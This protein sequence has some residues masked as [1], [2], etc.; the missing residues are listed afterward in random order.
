MCVACGV[1]CVVD[2]LCDI[3]SGQSGSGQS[4]DG[5]VE[6][7]SAVSSSAVSS[8]ASSSAVSSAVL[9]HLPRI[10]KLQVSTQFGDG[11]VE[12]LLDERARVLSLE[13]T[14]EV[15]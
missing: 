14:W 11:H 7:S 1:S 2:W 9:C 15:Y 6:G 5:H 12:G 4:G 10:S 8:A 3:A 13:Y